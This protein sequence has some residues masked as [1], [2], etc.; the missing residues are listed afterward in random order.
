MRML[1]WGTQCQQGRWSLV[2]LA[3]TNVLLSRLEEGKRNG[4]CQ[5]F[6]SQ[7]NILQIPASLVYF[8]RL[9][10]KFPSPIPQALFKPLLLCCLQLNYL[11][12]CLFRS[13]DS[14]FLLP[15]G[16]PGV[17]PCWFS[18]ADVKGISPPSVGPQCQESLVWGLILL[19]FHV[20]DVPSIWD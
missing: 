12:C 7:R 17:K 11:V 15:S 8:L 19:P 14:S 6:C 2:E 16:S 9:V 3:P 13:G 1:S 18:K 20:C 5:H 4:T 10:N